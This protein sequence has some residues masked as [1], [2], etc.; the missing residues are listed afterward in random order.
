[1]TPSRRSRCTARAVRGVSSR[2]GSSTGAARRASPQGA[3]RLGGRGCVA[4]GVMFWR[5]FCISASARSMIRPTPTLSRYHAWGGYSPTEG[6]TLAGGIAAQVVGIFAI[7]AWSA[8]VLTMVPA[9]EL[10]EA[11]HTRFGMT[12]KISRNQLKSLL[13]TEGSILRCA[14]RHTKLWVSYGSDCCVCCPL[15]WRP[16]AQCFFAMKKMGFLRVSE[17]TEDLGLDAKEFSPARPWLRWNFSSSERTWAS[18]VQ[19]M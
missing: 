13:S 12:S 18:E 5:S 4:T 2:A 6:A 1:M 7:G 14:T 10:S 15:T 19:S 11:W 3:L 8:I 16:S 9:G 17:D